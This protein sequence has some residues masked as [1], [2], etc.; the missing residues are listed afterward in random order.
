MQKRLLQK[1][2]NFRTI[3][4]VY[5]VWIRD[6]SKITSSG[7]RDGVWQKKIIFDDGGGA[8]SAE[9]A[10]GYRELGVWEGEV[11]NLKQPQFLPRLFFF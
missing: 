4:Q 7:G 8:S 10:Q 5:N 9:G 2:K 6:C 1:I 11:T 3:L